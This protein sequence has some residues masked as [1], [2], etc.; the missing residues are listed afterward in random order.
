MPTFEE[1]NFAQIWRRLWM[2]IEI[3]S[4]LKLKK[5]YLNL[6]NWLI[7]FDKDNNKKE[8]AKKS[9]KIF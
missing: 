8:T 6:K 7:C 3:Q 2:P 1:T 4:V 5:F 9:S